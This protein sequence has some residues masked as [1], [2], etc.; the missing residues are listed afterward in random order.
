MTEYLER[1]GVE[2]V[3]GM[4]GHSLVQVLDAMGRSSINYVSCRHEQLAAHIADGYARVSGKP[5]VVL[6]HVGPGLTNAVTGIATASLDCIPMVVITGN[7]QS[8]CHGRGPHQE[9]NLHADNDQIEMCRPICKRVYRVGRADDLPR[10]IERAFHLARSGRPGVV[11]VDVPMDFFS[12]ELPVGA[13]MQAPSPVAKPSIEQGQARSIA[14]ALAKAERPVIFAGGGIHLAKASAELQ[15]LA[16][17]LDVPV[18][19]TLMGK[20][21]LPDGHPLLLGTTGY[22]GQPVANEMCRNAD[23]ILAVGSRFGETD[24]SSWDPAYTFDIPKTRLIQIDI[25]EEEI[26]RNY[27]AEL[28][29]IADA[30][31]A[32]AAIVIAAEGLRPAARPAQRAKIRDGL[33]AFASNWT[34]QRISAE[35]PLRPE[36]VIADVRKALPKNG[37]IVTDVGWNKNGVG[38]Q[39]AIH[40]A[41]TMI[42]PGGMATMGFG[43]AAVL[44][45]KY[46]APSR[47]AVAL[48]GDG[49]FSSNMSVIA[50][51][52]EANLPVVWV[53][54]DNASYGVISGIEKRHL[55]GTYGC[56]FEADGE[57]Y[58]IDYAG[59]ANACGARGVKI[60]SAGQLEPALRE[61]LASGKPTLIQV[62][63]QLVPTPTTGHWDINVIF[64]KLAD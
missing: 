36:R 56:M 58:F 28:G 63:V 8:Y 46:A 62:P 30:K 35:F 44:G 14:E 25:S 39:F 32:L 18:A 10:V 41:G 9:I 13:F 31:Q 61:A 51:A 26:G 49:C 7:I 37:F 23:L 19:H 27:P 6:T 57:P 1:I 5:G 12:A 45:V 22:W 53:V 64:K 52:V 47:A 48:I 34:E 2:V 40:E 20:G 38:Q 50:T 60:E 15:A 4:C 24:S 59:V 33:A 17:M 21:C 42:T 29:V 43:H 54:M 16:E 55:G 11:L 3:F